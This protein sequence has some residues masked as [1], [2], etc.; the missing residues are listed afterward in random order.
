MTE[1]LC[2]TC[3]ALDETKELN[4]HDVN[5]MLLMIQYSIAKIQFRRKEQLGE[6]QNKSQILRCMQFILECTHRATGKGGVVSRCQNENGE[7]VRFWKAN[8]T[9]F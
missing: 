7:Q 3:M 1:I 9:S 6:G 2:S 5:E 8:A 4:I